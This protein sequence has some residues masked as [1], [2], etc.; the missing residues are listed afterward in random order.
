MR[1]TGA[2]SAHKGCARSGARPLRRRD[3]PRRNSG[4]AAGYAAPRHAHAG[5]GLR[6]DER[7]A[8]RRG[9]GA[10]PP[11]GRRGDRRSRARRGS[12]RRSGVHV[13][14][15]RRQDRDGRHGRHRHRN[16]PPDRTVERCRRYGSQPHDGR[17]VRSRERR[18]AARPHRFAE[19]PL[20]GAAARQT[21]ARAAV[22]AAGRG[23]RRDGRR[24]ERR[25]GAQLR[26]RGPFDGFGHVGG[27][28][29]Q[30]HHAA[31]RFVPLDR[32]GRHVGALALPQHPAVHPLPAHDQL[33]GDR[34]LP[35]RIGHGD[36]NAAHGDADPVGQHHHGHAGGHGHGI[37]AAAAR[38]DARTPPPAR[39][40]H[41]LAGD[42]AHD[43]HL[44]L[45]L[46]GRPA[47]NARL[48]AL[49]DGRAHRAPAHGILHDLRLPAILEPVQ[50]QRIRSRMRGEPRH[51]AQP[52]VPHRAGA[53]R[54]GAMAHRRTGRRGLPHRPA[55]VAGVG[56][57]RG[58]P[59]SSHW[60][61]RR[62]AP[63]GD[64]RRVRAAT[65]DNLCGR[66]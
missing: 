23:G 6:P 32:N 37:V 8:D 5:A 56:L 9:G 21:A 25:A 38:S 44:R 48:V 28:G 64:G 2:V 45:D 24:H 29:R 66:F 16:S 27:Q 49:H 54:A 17:R 57:D 61:A 52:D 1:Y 59:R 65:H 41:R 60:A 42:G 36:R 11:G 20:A 13:G 58:S 22:A 14:R 39:C 31:R 34:R 4:T 15:H 7:L 18:R 63:C 50:R 46:R 51:R 26:Q 3:G 10:V 33:R 40:E 62:S 35:R 30:R 12:R 55:L 19:N 43:R 53:H 47:R